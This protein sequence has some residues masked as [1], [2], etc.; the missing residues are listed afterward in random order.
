MSDREPIDSARDA[1][2]SARIGN[3]SLAVSQ[4]ADALEGLAYY[5]ASI[6]SDIRKI[7][8]ALHISN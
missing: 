1:K 6:Q 2:N 8:R 5:Q 3:V 7:K 4:L